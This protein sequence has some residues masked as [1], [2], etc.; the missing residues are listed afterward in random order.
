MLLNIT[1]G[2]PLKPLYL[3]DLA[4]LEWDK[5]RKQP[6]QQ[7]MPKTYDPVFSNFQNVKTADFKIHEN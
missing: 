1:F 2:F 6:A 4:G 7:L 3:T 5:Q